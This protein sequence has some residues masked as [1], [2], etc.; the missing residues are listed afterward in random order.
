MR[1]MI[2][3]W[4]LLEMFLL[5][6]LHGITE[7]ASVT[8]TEIGLSARYPWPASGTIRI[9]STCSADLPRVTLRFYRGGSY[10]GYIYWRTDENRLQVYCNGAAQRY[11]YYP[12][13]P[14]CSG[15]GNITLTAQWRS[16]DIRVV[17]EGEEVAV[18]KRDGRCGEQPDQWLLSIYGPGRVTATDQ[19]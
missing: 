18:R 12:F 8:L 11:T 9:S 14:D 15:G 5:L 1:K 10:G 16:D 19:G 13:T 7:A 3:V 6:N 4:F 17:Y 2:D